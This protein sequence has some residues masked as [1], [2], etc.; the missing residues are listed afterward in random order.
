MSAAEFIAFA[1]YWRL[2]G[3][4]FMIERTDNPH[5]TGCTEVVLAKLDCRKHHY[6]DGERNFQQL[7]EQSHP[8]IV[9]FLK[10]SLQ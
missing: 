4:Y 6:S 2:Y 10:S 1:N 3:G 5:C 7:K 8:E 9:K